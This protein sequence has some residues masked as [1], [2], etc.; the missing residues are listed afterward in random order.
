MSTGVA[1]HKIVTLIRQ[2]L[3]DGGAEVLK[4]VRNE[5]ELVVRCLVEQALMLSDDMFRRMAEHSREREAEHSRAREAPAAQT[6]AGIGEETQARAAEVE[7]EAETALTEMLDVV[8]EQ[9]ATILAGASVEP[10]E[11]EEDAAMKVDAA[12]TIA[13]LSERSK[14]GQ[15]ADGA[16]GGASDGSLTKPYDDWDGEGRGEE[17]AALQHPDDLHEL[18]WLLD[19]D[20]SVPAKDTVYIGEEAEDDEDFAGCGVMFFTIDGTRHVRNDRCVLGSLWPRTLAF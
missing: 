12:A 2:T 9:A 4:S 1:Q 6:L 18:S 13:A 7:V 20:E 8:D 16:A 17:E 10:E 5:G 3:E 15:E 14:T 19:S 11:P